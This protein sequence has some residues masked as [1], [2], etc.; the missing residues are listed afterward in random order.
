MSYGPTRSASKPMFALGKEEKA[1]EECLGGGVS[2]RWLDKNVTQSGNDHYRPN[3][4]VRASRVA[5]PR[6][7][8]A[9][10]TSTACR[11]LYDVSVALRDAGH[12]PYIV[13][14]SLCLLAVRYTPRWIT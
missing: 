14:S 4:R 9:R 2:G 3:V 5:R 12:R 10:Y 6:K 8:K 13:N 7:F 1:R 11:P